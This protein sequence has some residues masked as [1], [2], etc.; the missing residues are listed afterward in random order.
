MGKRYPN[1]S[2]DGVIGALMA[3][4][5]DFSIISVGISS[6]SA[7]VV[8]VGAT[9]VSRRRL[10]F[11]VEISGKGTYLYDCTKHGGCLRYHYLV[12]FLDQLFLSCFV[13]HAVHAKA[14]KY[15]RIS[16]AAVGR[17][18]AALQPERAIQ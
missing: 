3:D 10:R 11:L 18:L 9:F 14:P 13:L 5:A 7:D 15:R 8:H 1:G 6:V 16:M 2:Y 12:V 4:K 17:L